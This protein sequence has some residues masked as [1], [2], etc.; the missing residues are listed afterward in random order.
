MAVYAD[1]LLC[2]MKDPK[3]LIDTLESSPYFYKLKG[4]REKE[5]SVHLGGSYK[6]DDDE[7]LRRC[8]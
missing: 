5:P 6:R 2:A 8:L 7:T 4:N 1:D 3:G